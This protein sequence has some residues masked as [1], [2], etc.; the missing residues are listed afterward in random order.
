MVATDLLSV[1]HL[2]VLVVS[3]VVGHCHHGTGLVHQRG[4]VA[5]V[6]EFKA[7]ADQGGSVDTNVHWLV[8]VA[9]GSGSGS[10]GV[11]V[12]HSAHW[13]GEMGS[14]LAS[15]GRPCLHLVLLGSS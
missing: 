7:S 4:V 9:V 10:H 1:Q 14:L 3:I 6:A 15:E 2:L 5:T 8:E 11:G 13:R 12:H